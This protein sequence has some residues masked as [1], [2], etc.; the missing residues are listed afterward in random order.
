MHHHE[1]GEVKFSKPFKGKSIE[2]EIQIES[3]FSPASLQVCFFPVQNGR[4][5]PPEQ[6]TSL[7]KH[8]S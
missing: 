3:D 6:L 5:T 2:F 7:P 8:P 4:L 1:N